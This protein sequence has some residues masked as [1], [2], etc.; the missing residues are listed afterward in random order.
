MTT[1]DLSKVGEKM[2]KE[3]ALLMI[4]EYQKYAIDRLDP[5]DGIRSRFPENGSKN[6]AMRWLGFCQGLLVARNVY[7]LEEIKEHS[8]VGKVH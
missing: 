1:K 2:T 5:L 4:A 7:T 8:R 6:K 3:T